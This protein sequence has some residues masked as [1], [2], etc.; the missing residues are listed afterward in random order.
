MGS[1]APGNQI[2]SLSTGSS[3]SYSSVPHKQKMNDKSLAA[4][5]LAI[6]LAGNPEVLLAQSTTPIPPVLLAVGDIADCGPGAAKTAKLVESRPGLILALG[7][8][9]Y[10]NGSQ[11]D[12]KRCFM[13]TWGP[14]VKR[15]K[16]VPGNH[17]YMTNGAKP[18]FTTLGE[19][20]G[21][22]GKG[23]F[24]FDFHDWHIVGLNSHT[25]ID[26]NSPQ[27]Q[28][29]K[30][31]LETSSARCILAFVHLPRFS[32]GE[33]GDN[34]DVDAAWRL[35][36]QAGASLMLVGHDHIYERFAPLDA[37]GKLDKINGMRSFTVG[38]GGAYLDQKPWWQRS[39]SEALITSQW[40]ILKLELNATSYKWSFINIDEKVM[41]SGQ[42][43][44]RQRIVQPR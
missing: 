3:T 15:M 27:I 6:L 32:S 33:G 4:L 41:D 30:R 22:A 28:W 5:S 38:T 13:P 36:Q 29:L 19:S 7:D 2:D 23:Y 12:F 42:M 37:E 39:N 31:D 16:A 8:L 14:F 11:S 21:P 9:A 10:P 26:E 43:D 17:E 25:K 34:D 40:G 24:S 1:R 44:C 18:F 20:A 35:L